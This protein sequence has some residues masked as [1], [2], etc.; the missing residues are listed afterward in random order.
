MVKWL[1][2]KRQIAESVVLA[3][4]ARSWKLEAKK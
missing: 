2:G 3:L 1:I 4:E